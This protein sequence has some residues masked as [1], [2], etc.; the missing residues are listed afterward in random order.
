MLLGRK[1]LARRLRTTQVYT[2]GANDVL[3]L[4]VEKGNGKDGE[5]PELFCWYEL[6]ICQF[7]GVYSE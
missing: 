2:G 7:L 1:S 3:A 5:Y 6:R 4:V